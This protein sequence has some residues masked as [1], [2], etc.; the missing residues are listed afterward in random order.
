MWTFFA[1]ALLALSMKINIPFIEKIFLS[2]YTFSAPRFTL[3]N[4]IA[5]C[6]L[7]LNTQEIP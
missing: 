7:R 4:E 3:E 2:D 6:P 1:F 5:A